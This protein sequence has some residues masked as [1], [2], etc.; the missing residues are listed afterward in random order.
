MIL[1]DFKK[2][3]Q[4]PHTQ[5]DLSTGEAPVWAVSYGELC[6]LQGEKDESEFYIEDIAK[7]QE[8]TFKRWE[9]V[10][11]QEEN[12]HSLRDGNAS[13][14]TVGMKTPSNIVKP[15][16]DNSFDDTSVTSADN[17]FDDTS[18]TFADHS[19]DDTSVTSADNQFDDTSVTS[20]DN[21]FDDTSTTFADNPFDDTSVTSADNPFDDTSAASA[22]NPF[23]NSIT[24]SNKLQDDIK[25][26]EAEVKRL[27]DDNKM[28]SE[29]IGSFSSVR[30][31][32]IDQVKNYLY[33]TSLRISS[34]VIGEYFDASTGNLVAFIE[35]ELSVYSDM[36][37]NCRFIMNPQDYTLIQEYI[38]E[39][40]NCSDLVDS[41][42]FQADESI[43][44]G[45]FRLDSDILHMDARMESRCNKDISEDNINRTT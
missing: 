16:P 10:V 28:L 35:K 22:D 11:L 24:S 13:S 44:R 36:L 2:H 41:A 30:S 19:F 38:K 29:V 14:C 31:E 5:E 8:Y 33:N 4:Y 18:T 40:D 43:M 34:S 23:D 25:H 39:H 21:Q 37:H 45:G 42:V 15:S 20:A 3:L 32:Y 17:Q 27:Q 6:N 1:S 12:I 26:L 7:K 9:P